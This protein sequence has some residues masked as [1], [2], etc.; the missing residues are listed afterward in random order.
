MELKTLQEFHDEYK[1]AWWMNR[2]MDLDS[3]T[4]SN[5]DE[6]GDIL[7]FKSAIAAIRPDY[8]NDMLHVMDVLIDFH[9]DGCPEDDADSLVMMDFPT[10]R[11]TLDKAQRV[12][13]ATKNQEM[14]NLL[15]KL[16]CETETETADREMKELADI[17]HKDELNGEFG[18]YVGQA[19]EYE[20]AKNM[21]KPDYTLNGETV[22]LNSIPEG[23][24]I[25]VG[26]NGGTLTF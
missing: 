12:I 14:S 7:V 10:F 5:D 9:K 26:P 1:D 24:V 17:L 22:D 23:S 11:D 19:M 3:H 8:K 13:L 4:A 21:L 16:T 2:D 15:D 25:G 6:F 20:A 18:K